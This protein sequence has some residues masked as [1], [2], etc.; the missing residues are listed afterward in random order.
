MLH[1]LGAQS[2]SSPDPP[3]P[4]L[5]S[6]PQ[7]GVEVSTFLRVGIGCGHLVPYSESLGLRVVGLVQPFL[8]VCNS[9]QDPNPQSPFFG[10]GP[11]LYLQLGAGEREGKK[12]PGGT[13]VSGVTGLGENDTDVALPAESL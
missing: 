13:G 5:F 4:P 8:G 12:N 3:A 9:L 7:L 10:R 6:P 1:R 11:G 2:C